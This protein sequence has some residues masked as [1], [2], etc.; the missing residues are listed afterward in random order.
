MAPAA[1]TLLINTALTSNTEKLDGIKSE[2]VIKEER[3]KG[4]E[5][6]DS[7]LRFEVAAECTAI[8]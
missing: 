2:Y 1:T 3:L 5:A 8:L 6:E 7:E 4:E